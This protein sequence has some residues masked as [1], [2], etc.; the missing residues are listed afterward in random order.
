[1]RYPSSLPHPPA[2]DG[3]SAMAMLVVRDE[4]SQRSHHCRRHGVPGGTSVV[5]SVI[6]SR[7]GICCRLVIMFQAVHFREE[8]C[9]F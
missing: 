5:R 8:L 3:I 6:I 4:V 1:M 2:R 9:S 7:V